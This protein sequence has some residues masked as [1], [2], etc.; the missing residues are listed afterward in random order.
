[1][2]QDRAILVRIHPDLAKARAN[3]LGDG[4]GGVCLDNPAVAAQQIESQQIRDR[5]AIGEASSF[6]P[7]RPFVSNLP[8]E[9]GEEPRLADAGLADEADGLA[10]P[11]FDLPKEI[12]QDRE[13]A[14]AIDK[15]CAYE[16]MATR[17]ARSGDGKHR[18]DDMP[19]SARPC[20]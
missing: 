1:M 12:V 10:M 15:D 2:E 5:G 3:L 4:I 9:F 7:G 19:R 13:L 17:E 18:A 20:L 14:F 8:P 16:A 6:D 11:V